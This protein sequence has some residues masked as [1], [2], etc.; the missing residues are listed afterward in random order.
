[1]IQQTKSLN[2]LA[3]LNL[4]IDEFKIILLISEREISVSEVKQ[5]LDLEHSEMNA[6]IH[7]LTSLGII[8]C[9]KT[10]GTE[11]YLRIN[12]AWTKSS[13]PTDYVNR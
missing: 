1:M 10:G 13:I 3:I 7:R 5:D 8:K 9:S 11:R 6:S 12:H 2:E 4:F